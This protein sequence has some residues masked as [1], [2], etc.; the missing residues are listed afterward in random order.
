[1]FNI[2]I[3]DQEVTKGISENG[4]NVVDIKNSIIHGYSVDTYSL[5]PSLPEEGI[6]KLEGHKLYD[7][8]ANFPIKEINLALKK[9]D[10][11]GDWDQVLTFPVSSED[12]IVEIYIM[13]ENGKTL[14]RFIF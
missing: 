6:E 11:H 3:I 2:K 7:I 5:F 8:R 4:R 14:E 1:M 10:E 12:R 9:N 13:N